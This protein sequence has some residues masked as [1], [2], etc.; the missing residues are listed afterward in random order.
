MYRELGCQH[1]LV[2]EEDNQIPNIPGLTP[3]GFEKW[4]TLLIRTCPE[5]EHRRLQ[6]ALLSMPISNPDR[7]ERFPKD[8]SRRLF[9]QYE[10]LGIREHVE[11]SITKHAHIQLPRSLSR[12]KP[13]SHH[14]TGKEMCKPQISGP[15]RVSFVLS[16][17]TRSDTAQRFGKPTYKG[18]KT[19]WRGYIRLP[20]QP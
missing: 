18:E 20:G 6:K 3:T 4:V 8:I 16:P 15:R 9:P 1:H 10:D 13:H 19:N 11:Y 12:E 7:N 5:Q 14:I 17:N 2:Q